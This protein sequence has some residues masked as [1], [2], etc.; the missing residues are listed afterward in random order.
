VVLSMCFIGL[1]LFVQH[2]LAW[3]FRRRSWLMMMDENL[4]DYEFRW[5]GWD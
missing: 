1:C 2:V 5:G 3:L 4:H